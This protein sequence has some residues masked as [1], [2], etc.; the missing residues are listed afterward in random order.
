MAKE[1]LVLVEWLDSRGMTDS[2]E[3][4]DELDPM[5]AMTCTSVGFV[6]EKTRAYVTLAA[7]T[8]DTQV[9][10]RLTIPRCAITSM[11]ELVCIKTKQP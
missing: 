1:K 7:T 8:S 9:L 10:G 4:R 3:H 6:L 5:A 11:K 2:W